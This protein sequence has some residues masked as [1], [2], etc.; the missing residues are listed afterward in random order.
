MKRLLTVTLPLIALFASAVMAYVAV[1]ADSGRWAA[2]AVLTFALA[3]V[4]C[5][6]SAIIEDLWD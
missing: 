5:L 1:W 3:V 4:L 6:G 2:T